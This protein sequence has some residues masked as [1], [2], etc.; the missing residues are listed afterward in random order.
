MLC[1]DLEKYDFNQG[2]QTLIR[3][4]EGTILERLPPRIR[5]REDAPMEIPHIIA[6]IDD[7]QETVIEAITAVK[8]DLPQ[9]YNFELM[10]GSG[11]LAGFSIADP[12]LQISVLNALNALADPRTFQRKYDL[13]S[14]REVLLVAIGD[15]NHSL[16]TAK[17]IWEKIK[18][19]VSRDHPARYA[20]V[21]IEN[22]HD[23]GLD[24]EPIHRL[25][26]GVKED[27]LRSLAQYFPGQVTVVPCQTP[28]EMIA[29]VYDREEGKQ[30]IGVISSVG[31]HLA[32]IANP[33]LNLAVG[34]LQAFL[35]DFLQHGAATKID[36]IHGE[37]VLFTQGQEP[38]NA[39]F[40][41]PP[42]QKKDLFKTVILDGVLPRKTFSMGSAKE[43]RFY[44]EC[45]KIT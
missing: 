45:R 14:E 26:F 3:A 38:G 36:Y 34:S 2:S 5:I 9:L 15:G 29:A 19:H 30:Q 7:P 22:L 21:E 37:D 6:L 17:A 13:G 42:M 40:Y 18:P 43:K 8:N 16:A 39:G 27:P 35:D 11:H 28:Q 32:T 41:L 1:L 44:F 31:F 23:H 24:F 12:D 4:T 10:A 25:L 33:P 20:L